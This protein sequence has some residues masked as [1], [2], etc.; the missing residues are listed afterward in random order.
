MVGMLRPKDGLSMTGISE[1][2]IYG[3]YR[4]ALRMEK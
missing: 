2:A 3:I 1:A 4:G